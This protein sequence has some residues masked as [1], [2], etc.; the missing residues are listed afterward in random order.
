MIT[1]KEE[2][3]S[4]VKTQKA[5][6]LGGYSVLA[7]WLAMKAY[8]SESNSGGFVP[9]E[10]LPA[11][12][13]IPKSWQKPLKALVE[14]GKV[15]P[16]GTVGPGL[17]EPVDHGYSLHD[18]DDHGTPPE[19]EELRRRKARQQKKARR[20]WLAHDRGECL[21]DCPHC[22]RGHGPDMSGECPANIGPDM[23]AD[24]PP[25][26]PRA[27][28][29]ALPRLRAGTGASQPSPAQS[30][31]PKAADADPGP[32]S[33][34]RVRA[35]EE[36]QRPQQKRPTSFSEALQLPASERAKLVLEN[37]HDGA[38]LNPERWPEVLAVARALERASRQ[39]VLPLGDYHRD[40]GVRAVV[41]LLADGLEPA[42]LERIA[43]EIPSTPWWRERRRSLS[44]LSPE[45][46]RRHGPVG[47]PDAQP[48]VVDEQGRLVS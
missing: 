35:R 5:I 25:D 30:E 8:V 15:K 13:G 27:G 22:V 47:E 34:S 19:V 6:K 17:V 46:V 32:D 36:E 45:V 39:R 40:A 44:S 23:S 18:Y 2:F 38:W 48:L 37:P 10:A 16:D 11:L 29:G 24:C 31:D 14:C 41:G 3:L 4:N 12:P 7:V 21:A 20:A 28:A 1:V 33:P 26:A 42:E 9:A 43:S